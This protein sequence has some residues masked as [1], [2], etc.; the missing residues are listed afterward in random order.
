[1]ATINPVNTTDRRAVK[2]EASAGFMGCAVSVYGAK[3][4]TKQEFVIL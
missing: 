2:G 3:K 4:E 1:V